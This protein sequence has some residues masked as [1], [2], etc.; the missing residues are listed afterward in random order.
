M[1]TQ[2]TDPWEMQQLLM[3]SSAQHLPSTPEL[4][5]GVLLYAALNL[6]ES[7]ETIC[8]LVSAL[9]KLTTTHPNGANLSVIA[10]HLHM[11]CSMMAKCSISVRAE[12]GLLP[13]DFRSEIDD[14]DLIEMADGTT[15][16]AVT[17]AGFSLALGIDGAACYVEV[18][19]SNLSKRNPDTTVID[20]TIDGKWIK[21]R[22]YRK[23]DLKKIVLSHKNRAPSGS[24]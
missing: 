8:A 19:S 12:I 5:K 15:D 18:A 4:N 6:E 9:S 16:L 3:S 17:N 11:A 10:E 13:T 7:A 20:K 14:D 1:P 23:P 22:N 2:K 21:G 24:L